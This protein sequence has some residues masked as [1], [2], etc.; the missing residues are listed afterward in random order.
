MSHSDP[1]PRGDK[2]CQMQLFLVVITLSIWPQCHF[3]NS[4]SLAQDKM[5]ASRVIIACSHSSLSLRLIK[6]LV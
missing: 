2:L 5:L 6:V 3:E 1:Q 4:Q